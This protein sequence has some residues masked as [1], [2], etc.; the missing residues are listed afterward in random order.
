M[1]VWNSLFNKVNISFSPTLSPAIWCCNFQFLFFQLPLSMYT[2]SCLKLIRLKDITTATENF[3]ILFLFVKRS[4]PPPTL[5]GWTPLIH[6]P[7]RFSY[8]NIC[9][10]LLRVEY[11]ALFFYILCIW[12]CQSNC[13]RERWGKT[14]SSTTV[15]LLKIS[16]PM[17]RCV[18][19]RI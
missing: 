5:G 2:E 11:F 8:V 13:F 12:T 6:P 16:H 10:H 1:I 7:S 9:S 19:R 18:T 3:G 17:M 4:L 15:T 14:C